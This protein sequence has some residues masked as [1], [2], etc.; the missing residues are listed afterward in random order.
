MHPAIESLSSPPSDADFAALSA[1]L[2]DAI[3]GGASLGFLL[4]VREAEM[5]AY[6]QSVFTEVATGGRLLLVARAP[7]GIV[8][9]VQLVLAPRPHSRHRAELQKLLVVRSHRGRGLG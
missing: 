7:S 8:G 1:L 3:E 2:R 5:V 9:T 4:P 6:W